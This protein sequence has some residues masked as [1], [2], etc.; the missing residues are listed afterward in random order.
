MAILGLEEQLGML[1]E[2]GKKLSRETELN[3]ILAVLHD[4]AR[5]LIGCD[6]C[7]IF[8]YDEKRNELWTRVAHGVENEIRIPADKGVAGFARLSEEVQIVVDAYNDFRF[9]KEVDRETGYLTKSILAV[10]LFDT[11]NRVIG[12]FQA[13]NKHDGTFLNTDAELLILIGGYASAMLENAV[14]YENLRKNRNK[15]ILKLSSAAEFK[16]NETYNHTKRVGLYSKLLA[17]EYGLDEQ[18]SE[19]IKVASSMHDTG[20]IGIPDRV[21]LKPGKLDAQEWKIMQSHAKI[22]YDILY[23][24]EDEMLKMAAT[25]AYEHHEKYNGKGYPRGLVGEEISIEARI[26]AL[27]DVFDALVSKRPYKEPWSFESARDLI[28]SEAGEHFDPNLA[29]IFDREL[30]RFITIYNENRD[31]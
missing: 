8:I 9:N 1:L 17:L 21:L 24:N 20:K 23:D 27:A 31:E 3:R 10:P 29:A 11:K 22:G 28:L 4:V 12:V 26:T 15:I 2:L 5:D 25:I 19:R 14:L 18:R 16:D 6:R 13:L 7:S 30:Q